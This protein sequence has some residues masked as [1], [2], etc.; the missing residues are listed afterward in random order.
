MRSTIIEIGEKNH[1]VGGHL[2][3]QT[4]SIERKFKREKTVREGAVTSD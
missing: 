4:H 2:T 1:L 3:R